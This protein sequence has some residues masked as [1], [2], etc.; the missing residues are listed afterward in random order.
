MR[1]LKY[2][3]EH[4]SASPFTPTGLDHLMRTQSE[5]VV[6]QLKEFV[7]KTLREETNQTL[8]SQTCE[9]HLQPRRCRSSASYLRKDTKN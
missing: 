8:K 7:E 9:R 6:N 5:Q 3:I 2:M 1:E 4:P